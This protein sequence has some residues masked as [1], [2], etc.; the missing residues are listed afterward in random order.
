M[1]FVHKIEI[2]LE[3]ENE[4]L[5]QEINSKNNFNSYNFNSLIKKIIEDYIPKRTHGSCS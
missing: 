3:E 5:N 4:D 2:L 1:S